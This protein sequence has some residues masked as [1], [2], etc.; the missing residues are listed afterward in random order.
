VDRQTDRKADAEDETDWSTFANAIK[1]IKIEV[2]ATENLS[3]DFA[4]NFD[5][6]R[7]NRALLFLMQDYY[8]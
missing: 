4:V 7:F 1:M 6:G 5:V 8:A 3:C 2:R